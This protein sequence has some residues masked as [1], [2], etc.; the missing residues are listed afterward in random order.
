MNDEHA[1][2]P[3]ESR[4]DEWRAFA[5]GSGEGTAD[6]TARAEERL[7]ANVAEFTAAG[8][9][10]DEAF[11]IALK[12]LAATD[13]LARAYAR[14]YCDAL[15]PA[16]APLR[17]PE[18]DAPS[19]SAAGSTRDFLVMLGLAVGAAVAVKVPALFGYHLEGDNS[20]I[21]LVNLSLFV[22]PFLLAFF[23]WMHR[24]PR[25]QLI[26]MGAALAAG[27]V[28]ANVYPLVSGGSTQLLVGLHLPVALWLAV[29]VATAAG[30]WR[31]VAKRME[32]ARFTG[33]WFITYTLIALGGGVL[34]GITVGVFGAVGVNASRL[35]S[36]WVLPC[37]AM[38]AVLVAAWLVESRRNLVG[39]L[40]PMLARVFTPLFAVMLLALLGGV[41]WSR[42]FVNVG[43]EVL[44]LF[45]ALLVI[46]LALLLYAISARDPHAAPGL[47]D[48]IQLALVASALAVDVFALANIAVRVSEFGF[49]ANRTAALG[50]NL[51]LLVNLAWS[52][53][54]QVG[55]LRS[56]REFAEI[57]RWQM[58]YLPVY[59]I[60]AAIVV[61]AFPPLFG[62]A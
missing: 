49:S 18:P 50:L 47:F 43:R 10:A 54:L 62:F 21:Y 13:E 15:M 40:A 42:G 53:W 60:W 26:A 28:F 4:I 17:A 14:V 11:L 27:A 25:K 19:A 31:S 24:P 44:I 33:E 39:G 22:L 7:R 51:I 57:E 5:A 58:R 16:P 3:L 41:V 35:V 61:I 59:A 29:G 55:L 38:G 34:S 20:D 32:Y 46:V 36:D 8:L 1:Q 52:A 6:E 37:G 48:R 12:R 23:A 45:D 56:R 2:G 9:D 30:D